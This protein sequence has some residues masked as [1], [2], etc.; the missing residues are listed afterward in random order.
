MSTNR[1]NPEGSEQSS[2]DFDEL[3]EGI[4]RDSIQRRLRYAPDLRRDHDCNTTIRLYVDG[5]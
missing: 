1:H 4:T 3:I 2:Y 5:T